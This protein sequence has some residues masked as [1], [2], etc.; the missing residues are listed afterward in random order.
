MV[1]SLM[2]YLGEYSVYYCGFI[3]MMYRYPFAISGINLTSMMVEWLKNG[4]LDYYYYDLTQER[5]CVTVQDF[6]E[7]YS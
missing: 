1:I 2:M 6:Y 7:T 5:D 4:V 3:I